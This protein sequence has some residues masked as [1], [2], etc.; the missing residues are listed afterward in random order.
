VPR[1]ISQLS[2]E[3]LLD[4]RMCDLPVK[5]KGTYLESSVHRLYSELEVRGL[6]FKPHVWLSEE[7]FSP[8]GVAGFAIPFYLSH[9][10][11]MR[12][13]RRQMLEVEGASE[14]ECMRILRHEAGHALD[15]GFRLHAL[16]QWR[17]LFGPFSKPY[18]TFYQPEP[19]SRDYVLNLNAWY[20]QAHPAEDFAETFAVWLKP[21]WR[22]RRDY[23][24]WR[25]MQK[26]EYV[27][28]LMTQLI[29]RSASESSQRRVTDPLREIKRT[30]RDH[31][32]KKREFYK[33]HWPIEYDVFLLRAFSAE[34]RF[35]SRPTAAGFLRRIRRDVR[36]AVAN[37]TGMHRYMVD[38]ILTHIIQRSRGLNLHLA[39][40]PSHSKELAIAVVAILTMQIAR[41]GYHRI[42][43]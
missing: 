27:D 4:M 36:N 12:L 20:A 9:P 40:Q 35:T 2:D 38:H 15:N 42:P 26:L 6:D 5:I 16:R 34:K 28:Q 22:W 8:D 7:F 1:D 33:V 31:Y 41:T 30:L 18:P 19:D 13:E 37:T 32:V 3:A 11:L 43:L 23:Q 10:R 24:G 14:A 39:T 17:D 21:G 25:A 29:G